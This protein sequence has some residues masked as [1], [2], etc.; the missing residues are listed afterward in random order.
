LS[1]VASFPAAG[2]LLVPTAITAAVDEGEAVAVTLG[3]QKEV[4]PRKV[5]VTPKNFFLN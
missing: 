1:L 4:A 3:Q 2:V 5:L